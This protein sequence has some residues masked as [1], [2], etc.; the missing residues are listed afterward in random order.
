MADNV[1]TRELLPD[2]SYRRLQPA[3]NQPQVRSQERFLEMAALNGA[4]RLTETPPPPIPYVDS[5]PT[6]T[7]RARKRQTG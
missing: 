3:E 4:R 5:R 1:K 6:T 2:G 7:R